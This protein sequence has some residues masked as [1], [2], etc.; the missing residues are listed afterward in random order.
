A[1]GPGSWSGGLSFAV[2]G[3]PAPLLVSPSGV[4]DTPT[5]TYT[6]NAVAGATAYN[7]SV[8]PAT[9]SGGTAAFSIWYSASTACSGATCSGTPGNT[10]RPGTYLWYVRAQ[11]SVGVGDWSAVMAFR[12]LGGGGGGDPNWHPVNVRRD[13]EGYPHHFQVWNRPV[14]VA[15]GAYESRILVG[16]GNI[17]MGQTDEEIQG[18]LDL[19]QASNANFVRLWL[20]PSDGR[21][22]YAWAGDGR[23]DLDVFN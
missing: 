12:V 19:L 18:R 3:P 4:V 15:E 11:D 23:V 5:P 2:Q 10:L 17:A 6:W 16:F 21:Y 1:A 7:L 14:G 22:A 13:S 8:G 9:R 20:R